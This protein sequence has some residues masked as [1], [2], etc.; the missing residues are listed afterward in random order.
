MNK[1]IAILDLGTNTFHLLVADIVNGKAPGIICTETIA[2]K[3]GEGITNGCISNEAL[4]RGFL[5]M[6]KLNVLIKQYKVDEIKAIGTA[7]LR[8]AVNGAYFIKQVQ[9]ET[10]IKIELIDGGREAG[11]I[12]KG[13]R[14]AIKLSH[15]TA[16]IMDIGGGSVEFILCNASQLFWKKSYPVGAAKLMELFHHSDPV[17][18]DDINAIHHHLQNTL[19]ELAEQCSLFNPKVL[20]GAAGAFET[21]ASLVCHRFN[22]PTD[23]LKEPGFTFH[24]NQFL[25]VADH[26]LKSTHQ[27][28]SA[29]PQIIPVRTDMIVVATILTLYI[30][31]LL[32]T[33]HLKRSAYALKE[34]ML[35]KF[36]NI[37]DDC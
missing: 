8:T 37:V 25:I 33:D 30:I 24:T 20:I 32:K 14:E 9:V 31:N 36:Y 21:F 11:L 4:E 35:F 29:S 18:K 12:Y 22:L 13:V 7:A 27:Q 23:L 17:S 28:R 6:Q 19:T 15:E 34:G 2:V 3:L 26:I 1:R 5:A 10:G 16:L